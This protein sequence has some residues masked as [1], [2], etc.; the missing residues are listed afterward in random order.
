M[1]N[2][3][4]NFRV[5]LA[6]LLGSF[7]DTAKYEEEQKALERAYN[8]LLEFEKS[9]EF[10]RYSQL[11]EFIESP[12]F[13]QRKKEINAQRYEDTEAYQKEKRF[14]ELSRDK[15]IRNYLKIS[16]SDELAHYN[17]M[18]ESHELKRFYD[19]GNFF[20]SDEFSEFK[21]N[22]NEEREKKE[23]EYKETLKKFK[24]L[25]KKYQWFFDFKNSEDL[26]FYNQFKESE[27]LQH[28]NNLKEEIKNTD[29]GRLKKEY[30]QKKKEQPESLD[31]KESP[32]YKK[33]EEL[34][35]L[36]NDQEL[37]RFWKIER[38]KVLKKYQQLKDSP[39]IKD[40]EEL[41]DY[42]TSDEFKQIP[43]ELEKMKFENTQEYK[44]HQ[45]YQQLKKSDDIKK[46]LAFEKS[47]KFKLYNETKDSD[48]LKE[49]FDLKDYIESDEFKKEKEYYKTKDKFKL[50]DEYQQYLEY[51]KLKNSD[52]IQWYN[53]NVDS[54]KFDFF[55]NW[56]R[57][58][59][60]DFSN[61]SLDREK[62]ITGYY[63]GKTLLKDSYVQT[64]DRHFITDG[65]NISFENGNLRI[66]TKQEDVKG[67]AW[68]P[69]FGFYPKEFHYTSGMI[70]T[71]QSFRQLYGVFSAKV[72]IDSNAPVQHS[73]WMI[74]DKISPEIDVFYIN[75]KKSDKPEMK[76][77]C[78]DINDKKNVKISS[79]KVGINLSKDYYIFTLEWNPEEII[80]KVNGIPVKKQKSEIPDQPMYMIF[81]SGLDKDIDDSYLPASMYIDWVEAYQEKNT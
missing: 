41:S 56:H 36:K 7:P 68:H 66:L 72:K 42:V 44:E 46:V 17:R 73:F 11:K 33:Y 80:W 31:Y 2:A 28:Y 57:S 30:K 79:K 50:S 40:F 3:P 49:Y 70:N 64:D 32:E 65:D 9:E 69:S 43:Y 1:N 23:K 48:I 53:K 5:R 6:T 51:N 29:F 4:L 75:G 35:S 60:D 34:Q 16:E 54:P 27:K 15:A 26:A 76:Y 10:Q 67:K 24:Q 62:W 20:E 13:E 8:E 14:N 52:N 77:Y 74:A 19:L 39:E 12:E 55:R 38:S 37:K 78:G 47:P 18:Q 58:F 59:Y 61:G 81:N 63:W 45:E 21:N 22:L 25:R 71:G